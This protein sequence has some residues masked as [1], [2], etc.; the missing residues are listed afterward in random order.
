MNNIVV[1]ASGSGTNFQAIIEAVETGQI[2]AEITGLLASKRG[3]QA[4]ER[5]KNHGI[6]HQVLAP[7]EFED[8]QRYEQK[9]LQIL[10]HWNPDLIVLA[11]Y[12]L[13]VPDS[14]IDRYRG[15][16]INIHPSLLPKYG[17]KGYYGL[18]VHEAVIANKE[19][20]SGCTVHYVNETYDDGPIIEQMEVP[21]TDTDDPETLA[22]RVLKQE[23]TLLPR[24][25]A[26]LL[27]S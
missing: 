18:K 24:V 3:I 1:F 20:V 26:D 27:N 14:V 11:G 7:S 25:I 5:A 23:H 6:A 2:K 16:I 8:N 15:K 19:K 22:A 21:V 17:G 9:L 4:I 12:M 13:K 10:E